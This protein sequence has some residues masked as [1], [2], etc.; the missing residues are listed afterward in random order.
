M[1]TEPP[2]RDPEPNPEPNPDGPTELVETD[3][4]ELVERLSTGTATLLLIWL[5]M[6]GA[7][8][9]LLGAWLISLVVLEERLVADELLSEFGFYVA[10]YGAIGPT[11]LWLS[12]RAQG[13]G[14]RWFVLTALRIGLFMSILTIVFGASATLMLGRGVGPGAVPLAAAVLVVT[15]AASVLW[16]LGTWAA[17]RWIAQARTESLL[18]STWVAYRCREGCREALSDHTGVLRPTG[19]APIHAGLI[20]LEYSGRPDSGQSGPV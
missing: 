19:L 20:T 3:S 12:G 7:G 16:G 4:G 2:A 13:H 11:T 9:A 8:T 6:I 1:T 10:L 17:D 5:L 15:L 14:A 18:L